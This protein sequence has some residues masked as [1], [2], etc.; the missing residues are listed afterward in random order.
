M[1]AENEGNKGKSKSFLQGLI[2]LLA[3]ALFVSVLYFNNY[4]TRSSVPDE[5][6]CSSCHSMK[7]NLMTWEVTAHNK[8]GCSNCHSDISLTNVLTKEFTGSFTTPIKKTTPVSNDYCT[9]CHTPE[10]TVTGPGDLIIPHKLH[11]EKQ[12]SCNRCHDNVT[13][14]KVAVEV[15]AATGKAPH[16]VT[17]AEAT[18]LT[19]MG[20][21][22]PMRVCMEC[23][24]G[25]KAADNCSAC[26]SN[27]DV[28]GSHTQ[29]FTMFAHAVDASKDLASCVKCHEYDV[30]EQNKYDP[31][32]TGLDYKRT[33]IRTNNFCQDCHSKRPVTHDKNFIISHPQQVKSDTTCLVCHNKKPGELERE[34][35]KGVYCNTCHNNESVHATDWIKQH[36]IDLKGKTTNECF[37]CHNATSCSNCHDARGIKR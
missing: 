28:P 37:S 17:K 25:K 4:R 11:M 10:R 2:L 16:E 19:A 14:G 29:D 27:K 36:P 35:A 20:N 32:Q 6:L 33:Y 15:L 9:E 13:H 12:I 3:L 31:K 1:V 7:A 34:P 8:V 23:H 22:V 21:R 24:N 30:K 18:E 5:T 26:H